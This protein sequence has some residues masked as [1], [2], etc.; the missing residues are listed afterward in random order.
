MGFEIRLPENTIT[1]AAERLR[2][3]VPALAER[4]GV[5]EKKADKFAQ[6]IM[7]RK[8]AEKLANLLEIPFG[9]LYLQDLPHASR[10][11]EFPD[12]RTAH[13][14]V[15]LNVDF[16][17]TLADIHRKLDWYADYLQEMGEKERLPFVG[18]FNLQDS[19]QSVVNDIR[20]TLGRVARNGSKEEYLRNLVHAFEQQGILVFRNGIVGNATRRKLD[21]QMFR[22]FAIADPY[23]P[24]IFINTNDAHAAQLFTLLHEAAHIWL[25]KSAV[26]AP[27]ILR[28]NRTE[29]FCNQAAS[30]F[31]LPKAEFLENWQERETLDVN[32]AAL[33]KEFRVS[34]YVVAIKALE[35]DK[36]SAETF[37]QWQQR[38]KLPPLKKGTTGGGDFYKTLPVRNSRRLTDIVARAALERRILLRDGARLLN[39]RPENV[40]TYLAKG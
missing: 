9:F 2:M 23:T 10:G 22:G 27:T 26:S 18:K 14:A 11:A 3:N 6:G 33:A 25:G 34:E 13:D 20:G 1:S 37:R 19:I 5:T 40:M 7:T 12:F 35:Q 16:F 8:Q 15:P 24:A 30:E 38:K 28:D 21:P 31:L 32:L 39:T 36:I 29:R 17:D 4:I